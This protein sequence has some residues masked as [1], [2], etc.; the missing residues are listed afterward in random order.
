MSVGTRIFAFNDFR[1]CTS[2]LRDADHNLRNK[3]KKKGK[4]KLFCW[5]DPADHHLEIHLL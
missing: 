4:K 5:L 1:V 2:Y 3:K